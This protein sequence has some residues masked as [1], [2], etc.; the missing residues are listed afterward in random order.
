[1]EK[2]AFSTFLAGV[3]LV[4]VRLALLFVW[5]PPFASIPMS[6]RAKVLIVLTLAVGLVAGRPIQM[7]FQLG[8]L[9]SAAVREAIVGG[10]IALGL[11]VAFSAF[12]FAGR[13]LDYQIGFGVASLVD[14]ATRNTMPL[15]GTVLSTLGA[16]YFF[17]ID[18]HLELI[19]LVAYS[20]DKLPVGYE[21]TGIN[22]L[23]LISYFAASFSFGF[24][25]V[26]PVVLVLFLIDVGMAFM[27]RTMPQI[28]IFVMSMSVKVIVGLVVLAVS[29]PMAGSLI[30]RVYDASLGLLSSSI[31]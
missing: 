26:A 28:N 3:L 19:R 2:V 22:Q 9:L 4:S 8:A 31:K 16:V 23:A 25:A 7:D 17:C 1:M 14:I 12:H 18:G 15:L 27:S 11:F 10:A 20:L 21:I 13:L 6:S 29:L 24:V 5:A 30:G